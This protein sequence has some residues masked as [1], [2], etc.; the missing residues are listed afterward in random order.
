VECL[1]QDLPF[2]TDRYDTA[3]T[4]EILSCSITFVGRAE[5]PR[6]FKH[7]YSSAHTCHLSCQILPGIG[8]HAANRTF[9]VCSQS[10]RCMIS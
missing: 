1:R 10:H 2:W 9:Q 5:Y 4:E 7:T 6:S 3:T 8:S